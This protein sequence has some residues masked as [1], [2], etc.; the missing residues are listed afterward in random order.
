MT[1][2]LRSMLYGHIDRVDLLAD[3]IDYPV[4]VS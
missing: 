3:F 1:F 4:Q 2:K